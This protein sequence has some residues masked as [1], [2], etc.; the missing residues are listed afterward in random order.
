MGAAPALKR[1]TYKIEDS[2]R[3]ENV[4]VFLRGKL[5]LGPEVQLLLYVNLS[6]APA[7]DEVVGNLWSVSSFRWRGRRGKEILADWC[8][9]ASRRGRS[10]W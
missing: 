5:E 3:F 10:W 6:F 2:R 9:S 7:L 8:D 4:A 1:D